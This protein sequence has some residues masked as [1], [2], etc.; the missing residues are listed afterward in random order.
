M[1]TCLNRTLILVSESVIARGLASFRV[2]PRAIALILVVSCLFVALPAHATLNDDHYD[3]NI[4][5]LYGGNGS[6][7]PPRVTLAQSLQS[8]HRPALLAFYV[9]D[10]SDCKNYTPILNQIQ[11]FYSPAISIIAVAVDS[12]NLNAK[13]TATDE[14]FYYRGGLPQTVLIDANGKIIFDR[15]GIPSFAEVRAAFQKLPGLTQNANAQLR[16]ENIKQINEINP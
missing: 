13:H 6:L 7:V 10:S 8:L 2:I 5:A 1:R 15:E 14:A 12:L 16:E 4:F 9:D 11:S 3:G